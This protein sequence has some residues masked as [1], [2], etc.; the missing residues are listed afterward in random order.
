MANRQQLKAI[1]SIWNSK[2]K[3]F[4]LSIMFNAQNLTLF[5]QQC[6]KEN[7]ISLTSNKQR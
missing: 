4:E 1:I 6:V 7:P 2:C 5:F 3:Y